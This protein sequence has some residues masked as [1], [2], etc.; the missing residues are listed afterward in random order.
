MYSIVSLLRVFSVGALLAAGTVRAADTTRYVIYVH[1]D[2]QAGE[3]VVERGDD[4]WT[5]VHSVFK[6]NGRGPELSEQFRLAEDGTYANYDVKGTSTMGGIVDEHFERVGD[7]ARWHSTSES[8]AATVSGTALYVPMNGTFQGASVAANA[9]ASRQDRPLALFPGGTLSQRILDRVDVTHNGV[10]RH[11]SLLAFSGTDLTPQFVWVAAGTSGDD[12]RLFAFVEPGYMTLIEEGW[13]TNRDLLHAHQMAAETTLLKDLAGQLRRPL[14][15]LTVIRNARVFDSDTATLAAASDVYVLRGRITAVRPTGSPAEGADNTIDAGGRV[16]LPGLFDMHA[17]VGRWDGGLHLAA[18]V[19]TVRDMGNDNASLQR[20]LDDLSAGDL[21]S[22]QIVPAG[23]L[24]GES[25]FSARQG[26][27]V[28]DLDGAKH[29]IDWYAE[30]GYP[31]LKIYNSF[32]P[33]L[34]RETV[35]YAHSRG[36]RVSGHVPAFMRAQDVV[37]QGFD[38]VQHVNQLLLNFFVT[39]TTDTRTLE[40]FRLPAQMTADLDFDSQPVQD[41]IAFLKTRGTVVDPTL[42]TFNFIQQRDGELSSVYAPIAGHLPIN[43]QRTMRTGGFDIPDDATAK[44]YAASYA[45]MIDFV[46]RL[47]RA[48]IPIVAGTDDLPG[49]TL[50]RELELYVRAGMTPA[51]VLQIAT[52]SGALYTRTSNDRGSIVPGKLADLILV[53]GDPTVDIS[54]IRNVAC[55]ITQGVAISPGEVY[56]ALGIEPFVTDE[57]GIV[58]SSAQPE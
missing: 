20:M 37:E 1:G 34:V 50:Q 11:V 49:F 6:D 2:V 52:R 7:Q 9:F 13:E 29:A 42:A 4:G 31:Q 3:E 21:L 32:P 14:P 40:R 35:A 41:F 17:H 57:P 5:R 27:V 44:R 38:E 58:R 25:P 56:R 46:G 16:M 53:D 18:G 47:H 36:M 43:V 28:S 15:G 33:P 24:E 19:T 51:E 54:A 39:P 23:F 55:V 10:T 8:G 48:G 45:K 22:P 26:F 30:H 12:A